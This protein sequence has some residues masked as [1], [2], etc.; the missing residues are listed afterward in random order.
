M[1]HLLAWALTTL[2]ASL[3]LLLYLSYYRAAG[4]NRQEVLALIEKADRGMFC[5]Q[6]A[7][8]MFDIKYASRAYVLPLFLSSTVTFFGVLAG[9]VK[10]G[11]SPLPVELTPLFNKLPP[12][13]FAGFAGAFLSG[14]WEL[15]RRHRRLEFSPDVLHRMWHSLLAAPLT[16]TLLSAAFKED[17]ALLVALGVGA[18]PW[19][20]LIDLVSERARGVLK[21]TD[22]RAQEEAPTLHHLQGMTRE[23]IHRFKEEEITSI[24]HLAYANPINLLLMSNVN[25][26]RLLDLINQALLHCYLGEKCESLRPFGIRGAIEATELWTRAT[27]GTQEERVKAMEVL[28]EVAKTLGLPAP[29]IQNLMTVLQEE[30]QVV[31]LRGLGGCLRG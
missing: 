12:T 20:E 17:V 5:R 19:R 8:T 3:Y 31:F 26:F 30:P 6:N 15:I 16:A 28:N 10:A 29:A 4:L 18:T 7:S 27:Q 24:E 1:E 13:F 25:W 11:H 21:L 23:L 14:S 2:A 9:F 22:S